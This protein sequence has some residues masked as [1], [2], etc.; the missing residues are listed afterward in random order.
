MRRVT[1]EEEVSWMRLEICLVSNKSRK[2]DSEKQQKTKPV[3][4]KNGDLFVV[5]YEG[6]QVALGLVARGD[7]KPVRLGYFFPMKLFEEAPD[8]SRIKLDRSQAVYVGL[9][10]DLEI[11]RGNW[12]IVGHVVDFSRTAWPMPKFQ[13]F[14]TYGGKRVRTI[15]LYDEEDPSVSVFSEME[16]RLRS[17]FDLTFVVDDVMD[18]AYSLAIHLEQILGPGK[19]VD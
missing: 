11:R 8:R 2:K 13:R 9:F 7:S 17:D 15:T 19:P 4:T 18:G 3:R 1:A 6:R 10:G 5:I 16:P 14:N 12:P